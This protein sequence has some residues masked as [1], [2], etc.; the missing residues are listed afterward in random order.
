MA[1][2]SSG[3]SQR[4]TAPAPI[5]APLWT[6]MLPS[7][8]ALAANQDIVLNDGTPPLR[9]PNGDVLIEHAVLPN[10]GF[11][12]DDTP[13]TVVLEQAAFTYLGMASDVACKEKLRQMSENSSQRTNKLWPFGA[14]V[15]SFV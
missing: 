2:A 13:H 12:G 7:S 3:T 14:G 5:F 15:R 6:V 9:A 10:H 8:T 4:T 1:V 11:L